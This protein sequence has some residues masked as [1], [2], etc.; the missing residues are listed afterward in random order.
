MT[1]HWLNNCLGCAVLT[2]LLSGFKDGNE[3]LW[4][5]ACFCPCPAPRYNGRVDA[6]QGLNLPRH[7]STV[8]E[9]ARD[10]F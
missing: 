2:Q 5:Q 7:M 3:L 4:N 9:T 8:P 6:D 10:F 1:L